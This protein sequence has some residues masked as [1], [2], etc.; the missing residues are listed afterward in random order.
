MSRNTIVV[1]IIAVCCE[2]HKKHINTLCLENSYLSVGTGGT[3]SYQCA[4]KSCN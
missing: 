2:S 1:A 4:S 3:Y